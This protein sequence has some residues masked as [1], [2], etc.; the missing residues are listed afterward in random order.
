MELLLI[1]RMVW[2]WWWLIILPIAVTALLLIPDLLQNEQVAAG[3]FY[4]RFTYSAAQETS[5]FEL[6]DGDYQDVWLASEFVVNAFT[7][8]VKTSSFRDE[9]AQALNDE[10]LNLGLLGIASDNK[11]SIGI[12]EMSYP[13]QAG[14][15]SIV[16]AAIQVL[17]GRN[18]AYFPHLGDEAAIV[19]ILDAPVVTPTA[20]PLSNRLEPLIKILV[21]AVLGLGL[22]VLA[23]YFDPTLRYGDEVEKQG[24]KVLARIPK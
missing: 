2:R 14:L 21:A 17:Q 18:Q 16:N 23:E 12:V 5:N 6:R 3:S 8:W 4:T 13:T 22:A 11:R 9:I 24:L 10:T 19:T 7:D 1:W 20:A 15:E